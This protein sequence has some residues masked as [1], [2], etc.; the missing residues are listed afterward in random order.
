MR[1]FGSS[2]ETRLFLCHDISDLSNALCRDAGRMKGQGG[3]LFNNGH[4]FNKYIFPICT[5]I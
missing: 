2:L 1:K 5:F 3:Q 4:F